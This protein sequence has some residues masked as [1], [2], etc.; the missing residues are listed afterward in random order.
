MSR[1]R[2]APASLTPERLDAENYRLRLQLAQRDAQLAEA[3]AA[4]EQVTDAVRAIVERLRR[5]V[6]S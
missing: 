5:E 4:L 2:E 1:P 6:G 3:L